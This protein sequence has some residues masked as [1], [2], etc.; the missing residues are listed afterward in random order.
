MGTGLFVNVKRGGTFQRAEIDTLN[1]D[2]LRD[3]LERASPT[4]MR[5]Y[6]IWLVKWIRTEHQVEEATPSREVR[7]DKRAKQLP[8]DYSIES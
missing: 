2:E 4:Q 6:C 5:A 7:K 3:L 8:T 1:D